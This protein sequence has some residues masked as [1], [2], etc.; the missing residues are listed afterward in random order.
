MILKWPNIEKYAYVVIEFSASRL[1]GWWNL[2]TTS[3]FFT[4]KRSVSRKEVTE[5]FACIRAYVIETQNNKRTTTDSEHEKSKTE[6]LELYA[7]QKTKNWEHT[8]NTVL[9][10][11]LSTTRYYVCISIW[12]W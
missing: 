3:I 10:V 5:Q 12:Q 2:V 8:E 11:S 6:K 4:H 9:N 7:T 1:F